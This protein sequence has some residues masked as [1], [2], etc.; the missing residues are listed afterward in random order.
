MT[1]PYTFGTATTS[2]PLSNLDANF[3]TPITLGNTSIYLGNTTT[4]IGNLT[5]TNATISSGNVT[6][7]NI[8]VTTAN[9]TTANV[10]TLSV[11]GTATISTANITTANITTGN[12]TTLT[13]TSITD[14]GLTSGRVT[15]AGAS[16]LLTDSSKLTFD[17]SN[18]TVGVIGLTANADGATGKLVLRKPNEALGNGQIT[19]MLDFAPYYP[20]FDEAV[21]KASIFSGVDTGTQNGQLGF[22][23]ATGGVLS[24]K[25]RLLANGNLGIGTSSPNALLT[26][27]GVAATG[28]ESFLSTGTTTAYNY[29]TISNT[30]SNLR[31]GIESS[32][33]VGLLTG[34]SNYSGVIGTLTATSLHLGTN[35]TVRA[36]IDSAGN[37]GIG[38]T[39]AAWLSTWK[40]L[41]I[42]NRT[43]LA[44]I[45]GITFLGNNFYQNTSSQ[46]IYLQ[47]GFATL[48]S[49]NAGQHNWQIAPSGTAGN[50]ITL[51]T[52]MVLDT[53]GNLGLGVTPSAW[54]S[55]YKAIQIG[56]QTALY[57]AVGYVTSLNT[58]AYEDS[59]GALRRIA[60][61]EA[62]RYTQAGGVHAFYNAANGSAGDVATFYET[63]NLGTSVVTISADEGNIAGASS[64]RFR[65][66]G[67]E[68][69]RIDL[70]GNLLVGT[71]ST[72]S[73]ADGK[74]TVDTSGTGAAFKTSTVGAA[75]AINWNSATSGDNQFV[76][77]V[78]ETSPTLR[79]NIAYNR[80]GGLV[81]YNVTSDYRA[82]DIISTT[83]NSGEVIDSVPVYMGKMKDATQERPMFIA[84]E[85]PSYAHTGEKDAVDVDGNPVYQQMD[86]S[87]LIPVMWAEIQSLRQRIKTLENK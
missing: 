71:T 24:E 14:S 12:I 63:L 75:A 8:T 17:T 13:S 38:V 19:R 65:T 34:S 60:S 49:Q 52:A 72:G 69:A 40:A 16:G 70:D 31:I 56:A 5:L 50:V 81:A 25:M 43:S 44:E 85:T 45:A 27:G 54:G 41:Q 29:A 74:I 23:T 10:A 83:V 7:S 77:F 82:K 1:V 84:H 32:T 46:N 64:I 2:I 30:G 15:Y 76:F 20:G 18:L 80:A 79:G 78:T 67:S 4:T 26:L 42:S 55:N 3:N 53:S 66:D 33:A 58:N 39:P 6:I 61:G 36:T 86:A 37:V 35:S 62:S 11:T 59:A 51:T 68:R 48:Y 22:M 21:V 9:V 73:Y 87:T 28:Y 57:N 47:T